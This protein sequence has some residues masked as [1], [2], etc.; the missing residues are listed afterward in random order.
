MCQVD[1][2]K[3]RKGIRRHTSILS[4]WQIPD[5]QRRSNISI[6]SAREKME[7][8]QGGQKEEKAEIN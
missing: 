7:G 2:E 1:G 8:E 6:S 5:S 4:L 3:R